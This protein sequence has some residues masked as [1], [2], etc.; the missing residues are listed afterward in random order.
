MV[1]IRKHIRRHSTLKITKH[2]SLKTTQ[3]FLK[4]VT[5]IEPIYIKSNLKTPLNLQT[6]LEAITVRREETKLHII[7][8]LFLHSDVV[9]EKNEL[10][11]L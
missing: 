1:I 10:K 11:M 5:E 3:T 4:I 6:N 7:C 2:T 8:N 9:L